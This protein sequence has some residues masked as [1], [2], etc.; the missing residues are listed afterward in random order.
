LAVV[1]RWRLKEPERWLR[2]K[3]SGEI[4]KYSAFTYSELF[5]TPRWRR[6]SLLG[7]LLCCS[8]I[9][10]MWGIVFFTPELIG[11]VLS[12]AFLAQGMSEAETAAKVSS[13]RST[14]MLVLQIG[15][16]LGML[17]SSA[18]AAQLPRFSSSLS[19]S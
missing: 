12:K 10:G 2:L 7:M 19:T 15:A 16:F 14:G 8:G 18:V 1:I 13:W 11:S 9:I 3:E 17:T 6:N 4:K 5:K